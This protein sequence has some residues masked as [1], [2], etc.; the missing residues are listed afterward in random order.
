MNAFAER[1]IPEINDML[2]KSNAGALMPG[3]PIEIPAFIK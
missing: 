2:Q 3:N 1:Q